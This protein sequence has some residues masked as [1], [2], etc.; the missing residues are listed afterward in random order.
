MR[1][2]LGF[3]LDAPA[4]A[5][6]PV[7]RLSA[8][9]RRADQSPSS[10]ALAWA[11]AAAPAP[12][13]CWW[14]HRLAVVRGFARYLAAL[15][16]AT[17]VPPADA[18]ARPPAAGPTPYLYTDADI[19]ALMAAAGALRSPLRAATYQTL[20]GLLAVTGM[21]V[22]EAIALDRDDVD[23]SRGRARGPA[24]ASSASPASCRCTR[25]PSTALH[26]YAGR[27]TAPCSQ[28][29]NGS[30]LRLRPR[31]PADLQQRARACSTG[32]S[33]QTGPA[34]ALGALPPAHP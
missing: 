11:H 28:P 14:A 31:H 12:S 25:P 15:D 24:R 6:R 22:G 1:R 17:E 9:R 3:K 30:V 16:P 26:D 29:G 2:A 19:A 23:S 8:T 33:R 32:W 10:C 7:R 27:A 5:A 18:A 13:R 20:I 34:A 4:R 21:R